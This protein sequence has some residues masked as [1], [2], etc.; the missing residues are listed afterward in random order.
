MITT[1]GQRIKNL[2]DLEEL[3]KQLKAAG[4]TNETEVWASGIVTFAGDKSNLQQQVQFSDNK[5]YVNKEWAP[6]FGPI[7]FFFTETYSIP[8]DDD[9]PFI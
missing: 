3:I 5:V 9:G 8:G 4:A 1:H 6:N 7:I 2:A